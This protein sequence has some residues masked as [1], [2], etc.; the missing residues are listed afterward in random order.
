MQ[1][2]IKSKKWKIQKVKERER[3]R[4]EHIPYIREVHLHHLHRGKWVVSSIYPVG[5]LF[6]KEISCLDLNEYANKRERTQT[7]TT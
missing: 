5:G 7:I 2:Y 4:R 6:Q 1:L 3:G